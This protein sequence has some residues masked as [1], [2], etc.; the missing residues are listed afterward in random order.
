MSLL[1][2]RREYAIGIPGIDYEHRELINLINQLHERLADEPSASEAEE[3]LGEVQALIAS[4]FALEETE[5]RSRRYARYL[6]HKADHERLLD[7]IADISDDIHRHGFDA[8]ELGQR[9]AEWFGV[10]FRTHDALLH[11]ELGSN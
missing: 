5:M 3:F 4:H 9:L 8:A 11:K 6:E 1:E 2:W 10:H 7:E